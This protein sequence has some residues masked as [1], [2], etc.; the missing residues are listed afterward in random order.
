MNNEKS[1]SEI[2]KKSDY[3][4]E[5]LGEVKQF[6]SEIY[7]KYK[8]NSKIYLTFTFN[9][10]IIFI[11]HELYVYFKNKI[12]P[13]FLLIYIPVTFPK[14]LR[15]YI[16]KVVE[17]EINNFYKENEIIDYSTLELYYDKLCEYKPLVDPINILIENLY[18]K[19]STNFPLYKANTKTSYFGPCVLDEKKISLI[20]INP[21]DLKSYNELNNLKQKLIEKILNLIDVKSYEIQQA[22]SELDVME[23]QLDEQLINKNNYNQNEENSELQDLIIKLKELETNLEY[24]VNSLKYNSQKNI[25]EKCNDVVNIKDK[26][27]Y[28]YTVMKKTIED[29]LL[30]IKKGMEKKLISFD[31]CIKKTRRLSKELF[32]IMYAIEKR[33]NLSEYS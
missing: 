4:K 26:V 6:I 23:K 13:I 2:L 21:E 20:E 29:F 31:E 11:K 10:N 16:Q 14:E 22:S 30:Y 1:L 12:Y 5:K 9:K 28:K 3:S 32:F 15:I 19:F 7:T 25:L 24:Q 17:M 27:K 18:N 33:N 8:E